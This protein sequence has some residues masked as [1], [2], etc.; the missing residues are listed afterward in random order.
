MKNWCCGAPSGLKV[1]MTSSVPLV[2]ELGAQPLNF[3]KSFRVPIFPAI[4]QESIFVDIRVSGVYLSKG[5]TVGNQPQNPKSKQWEKNRN[6]LFESILWK[7]SVVCLCL[8]CV[9]LCYVLG[10][11]KVLTGF[12]EARLVW[13]SEVVLLTPT[14][15]REWKLGVCIPEKHICGSSRIWCVFI[16]GNT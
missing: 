4:E 13:T 15:R 6:G 12:H 11:L 9:V 16:Y 7:S 14:L 8:L 1:I 10:C 2:L 3:A 5:T